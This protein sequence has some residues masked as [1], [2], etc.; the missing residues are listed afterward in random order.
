MEPTPQSEIGLVSRMIRI[1][2]APGET[3][4]SLAHKR[5]AADWLVPAVLSAVVVT[6][7]AVLILPITTEFNQEV[8][9]QRMQGMSAEERKV[10]EQYQTQGIMQISTLIAT[11][12]FLLIFLF[13]FAA[14]YMVMGKLLGGLLSYGQVLAIVAYAGLITIPQQVVKTLL[15][16]AKKTPVVQMGLGI[17]LSEEALQTFSGRLLSLIDPFVIWSVVITSLGLSIIGQ[18]DRSKAY[19]GVGVITLIWLSLSSV[20]GGK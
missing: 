7:A 14:C 8:M 2:Y 1:F 9:Q 5:S 10:V 11:P 13:V 17:F 4:E 15:I 12:I 20:L 16:L 18:L 3:F 6:V 19:A